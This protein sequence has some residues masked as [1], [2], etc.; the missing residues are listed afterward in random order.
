MP[1]RTHR[2]LRRASF[3]GGSKM[4]RRRLSPSLPSA[5]QSSPSSSSTRPEPGIEMLKRWSTEPELPCL[6]EHGLPYSAIGAEDPGLSQG[7]LIR[8]QTCTDIFGSSHSLFGIG[9]S[10]QISCERPKN[11]TKVVVNVAVEGSPGP[12]KVML[13]LSST[14]E[15]TIKL[16]VG[17]YSEE[18]RSPKLDPDCS[19]AFKLH[20]SHFSLQSLDKSKVM[21]DLGSR[22]FY[23]RT[24]G[25]GNGP[26]SS[27]STEAQSQPSGPSS[28]PRPTL[29]PLLLF[30]SLI[31]QKI[32]MFIRRTRKFWRML[33]CL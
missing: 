19:S 7:V 9:S 21:G 16:V 14:V 5:R 18:G 6:R 1:E 10:P 27:F 29:A 4:P 32:C 24:C 11:E 8:P 30:P 25:T 3:S 12:V 33:V 23:L 20:H 22:K 13:K 28:H 15:E 17:K 26:S 2:R 31:A